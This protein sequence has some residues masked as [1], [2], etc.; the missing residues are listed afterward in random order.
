[1]LT[2]EASL[3]RTA[4][5]ARNSKTDPSERQVRNCT[6]TM[7]WISKALQG[8]YIIYSSLKKIN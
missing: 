4:G 7:R 6:I 5:N 1:M 8:S 3:N 2:K